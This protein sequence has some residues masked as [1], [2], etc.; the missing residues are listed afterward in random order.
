MCCAVD[1]KGGDGEQEPVKFQER[2]PRCLRKASPW[3]A[4]GI[5]LHLESRKTKEA[6]A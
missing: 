3:V 1:V 5:D 4:T 2:K 6:G